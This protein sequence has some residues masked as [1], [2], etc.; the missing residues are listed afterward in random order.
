L[1]FRFNNWGWE[2]A[3]HLIKKSFKLRQPNFG[4]S[5]AVFPGINFPGIKKMW[6]VRFWTEKILSK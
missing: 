2:V 4:A 3:L 1:D 6:I 5:K